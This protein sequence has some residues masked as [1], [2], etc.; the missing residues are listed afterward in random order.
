MF[1]KHIKKSLTK[2]LIRYRQNH[3]EVKLIVISG[4][5]DKAATKRAVGEVLATKYRV[6]VHEHQQHS[7]YTFYLNVLGIKAPEKAKP[8]F[9]DW[10]RVLRA[11]R[12]RAKPK[13]QPEVD[14][15]IQEMV[16]FAPGEISQFKEFLRPDI[17]IITG[18]T[19]EYMD[20]FQTLDAVANEH[21]AAANMSDLAIICRDTINAQFAGMIENPNFTTYGSNDSAEY[22]AGM[23]DMIQPN[24]TPIQF[25]AV[26]FPEPIKTSVDVLGYSSIRPLVAAAAIAVKWGFAASEIAAI[27]PTIT[28]TPGRMNPLHGI[29]DTIVI[30]DTYRA[31]PQNAE[32]ALKTLY[33]FSETPQRIAIFSGF[34]DMGP[35]FKEEHEKIGKMCNPDLLSWVVLV[36]ENAAN[37]IGPAARLKGCQVKVCNDAIEAGAFVRSV[38]EKGAVILVEGSSPTTYLEEAVKVLCNMTEEHQLVRQSAEWMLKKQEHFARVK[39]TD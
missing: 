32:D 17:A 9:Y 1:K 22:W 11:A 14:V 15:I 21:L 19:P 39:E 35:I 29:D 28:P 4:S 27:I 7:P 18:I 10:M 31:N 6:R 5:I 26:E 2:S 8:S 16:A 20:V 25:S 3:P 37:Y 13:H 30:D 34:D 33:Q 23:T 24:G 36:G 38:T 12:Y